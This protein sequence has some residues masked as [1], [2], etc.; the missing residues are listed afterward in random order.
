MTT[1][2]KPLAALAALTLLAC[3]SSASAEPPPVAGGAGEFR[4]QKA[5]TAPTRLEVKDVNGMV[6][7][8]PAAGDV[9]EV[10]AVKSGRDATRVQVVA[11]E[12]G[13]AILLCALWPGQDAA[14]CKLGSSPRGND[15]NVDA[16]VDFR[17]RVPARV[18]A[19][20]AITMNGRVRAAGVRGD[21]DVSTMNGEV[22]V[23]AT[24]KIAA[25]T[26]NGAMHVRAAAG[27][28]VH[29]ETTNGAIEVSLPAAATADVD[30]STT[31]G[32]IS[33][34]F[35]AVPPPALPAIHAARFKLGAGG[36]AI[37]LHTTNGDVRVKKL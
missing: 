25:R 37:S 8:E 28:E 20:N 35:V 33:S 1:A 26:M 19:L 32:R 15:G 16:T 24:G 23:E 22:D 9:L 12:E 31:N 10:V 3:A 17:I 11:R 7:V 36:T 4:Y 18:S 30:A 34:D 29:L 2:P 13:G 21:A 27:R 5:L 14:T 6:T